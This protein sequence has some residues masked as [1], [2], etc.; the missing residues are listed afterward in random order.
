MENINTIYDKD[1]LN[2][3]HRKTGMEL[4]VIDMLSKEFKEKIQPEIDNHYLSHL[5]SSIESIINKERIE[6]FNVQI[7]NNKNIDKEDRQIIID[8]ISNNRFR[9]YPILLRKTKGLPLP[10]SIDFMYKDDGQ[11]SGAIIYYAEEITDKKQL[12]IFIAHELGHI[13]FE[14]VSKIT[15]D[16]DKYRLEDYI[17]LFALFAIVDKDNFYNY[18]CKEITEDNVYKSIDSI[19]SILSQVYVK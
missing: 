1:F 5:V 10:A 2:E 17:N 14:A 16:K 13:Y 11:S 8:F 7:A 18:K 15:I 4:S 19:L 3:V 6:R 12:R 9:F